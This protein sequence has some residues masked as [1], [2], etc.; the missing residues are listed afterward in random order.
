MQTRIKSL[1][2]LESQYESGTAC[3][4]IN[5]YILARIFKEQFSW[6]CVHILNY[7]V[8]ESCLPEAFP[9]KSA[10]NEGIYD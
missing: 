7:S 9:R 1:V 5:I 4:K 6:N 2:P 3:P 8:R 10:A